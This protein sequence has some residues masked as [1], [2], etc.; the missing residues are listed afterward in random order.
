MKS[1]FVITCCMLCLAGLAAAMIQLTVFHTR[2][3]PA[4]QTV[5]SHNW[6]YKPREDGQQ[7][8]LADDAPFLAQYPHI[9]VGN[10][11][12]KQICLTFDCG[13]DNGYTAAI[14]DTLKEKQVP[15]AFFVTGHFVDSC[16][17]LIRRMADEGHL[18]CNHSDTHRDLSQNTTSQIFLEELQGVEQKYLALTGQPMSRYIRPP[19]G[20]YSEDFLKLCVQ[21]KYLP[22]FWSFAY[23][24]WINDDQPDLASAKQTILTRTHPGEIAL[25]HAT[26]ATNAAILGDVID[27]WRNMG[28]TLS[29]LDAFAR[30]ACPEFFTAP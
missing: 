24:D 22:V 15:A 26:S 1:R 21:H 5:A 6:Y 11:D 2:N 18:V 9:S 3:T 10:A 23:C 29:G 28:Y 17:D 4:A 25:L 27:Q 16:P 19:E 30:A 7:P 12:A 14:L 20:K 13:Y 8:I